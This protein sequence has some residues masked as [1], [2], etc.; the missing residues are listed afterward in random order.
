M[1]NRLFSVLV[2][3]AKDSSGSFI[4]VRIPLDLSPLPQ[5]FYS[6]GRHVQEGDTAQ[7]RK[8]LVHGIY[9]SI[10]RVKTLPDQSIEWTM[11]VSSDAKGS[12]PMPMQKLA[13]PGEIAKDVGFFLK[14]I[15]E[16]RG[17]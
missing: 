17:S 9:T 2:I 13:L 11:T 1:N 4:I 14:W 15:D 12:L 8:P 6:R 3:S 16:E 5:A 10:E 7:K